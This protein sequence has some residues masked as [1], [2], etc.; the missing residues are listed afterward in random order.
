[1]TALIISLNIFNEK[2]FRRFQGRFSPYPSRFSRMSFVIGTMGKDHVRAVD[3]LED[4][5]PGELMRKGEIAQLPA[6]IAAFHHCGRRPKRPCDHEGQRALH[7]HL[8]RVDPL[9]KA[10]AVKHLP[11]QIEQDDILAF[12]DA[13]R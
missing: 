11:P 1:M 10:L 6:Q 5:Q 12:L 8:K 2:S 7:L 4:E 9:G 3:L 13:E